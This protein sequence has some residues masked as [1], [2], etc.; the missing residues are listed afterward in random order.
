MFVFIYV[1]LHVSID[2]NLIRPI[3]LFKDK[4]VI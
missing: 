2:V 4:H 1:L 3:Y